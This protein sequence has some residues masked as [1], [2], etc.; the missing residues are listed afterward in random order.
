MAL[1]AGATAA[2]AYLMKP[3]ID[4]V[5]VSKNRDMLFVVA[6]VVLGVFMLRGF[7]VYAQA[8]LMNHIGHRVVAP[9]TPFVRPLLVKRPLLDRF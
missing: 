3:I 9:S 6:A 1:A 8:A 5:F 7:V 2:L 4:D